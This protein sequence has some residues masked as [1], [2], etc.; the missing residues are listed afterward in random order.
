MPAPQT[1]L[2]LN[3]LVFGPTH[4][5]PILSF[6]TSVI[7]D[8][9]KQM[10][11]LTF[12]VFP[13][14]ILGIW[15][16]I[17]LLRR[18][19]PYSG[20]LLVL[21]A[22]LLI[23]FVLLVRNKLSYYAILFTPALCL[24][25]AA[26]FYDFLQKRTETIVELR[27]RQFI[28]IGICV[29]PMFFIIRFNSLPAYQRVQNLI[30]QAVKPTDVIMANQLYWFGLSDHRYY[31]W[32]NLV[33]YRRYMPGSSLEDAF[34]SMRPDI[35]IIDYQVDNIILD[36]KSEE[37]YRQE[38]SLPKLEL[39]SFLNQRADLITIIDTYINKPVRIYRIKW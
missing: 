4:I 2:R 36:G 15:A 18:H 9:F 27:F 25:L 23:S 13:Q 7:L 12:W 5:P 28:V 16:V 3:Q 32:E 24:L 33:F 39:E 20:T 10:A 29:I 8:A 37:T 35:F 14:V 26:F 1:F 19:T 31:S 22:V 17:R 21:I 6:D 38:F 11:I 34:Q 30:N